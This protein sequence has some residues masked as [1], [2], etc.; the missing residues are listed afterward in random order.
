VLR[1][2]SRTCWVWSSR[3]VLSDDV[4]NQSEIP[5]VNNHYRLEHEQR[6]WPLM[7]TC[8]VWYSEERT[9]RSVYL[10]VVILRLMTMFM[11]LSSWKGHCESSPGSFD[12]CRLS[13][14][15]PPTLRP[16]QLTWTVSPSV[17]SYHPHPP[18]PFIS[19]TQPESWYSF[20]FPRRVEGWVDLGTAVRACSPCP[21]LYIA[22]AV[23]INTTAHGLSHCS[24]SCYH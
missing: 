24:R 17:G 4:R 3:S 19:I 21:R 20:Y 5:V 1:G 2:A 11:V 7:V 23:M 16:S 12:E 10:M 18:S 22:V 9:W 8:Y 14:R 15:W 6:H 13:D